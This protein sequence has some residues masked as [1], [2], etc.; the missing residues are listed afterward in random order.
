[1]I[2]YSF[3]QKY[4]ISKAGLQIGL[5]PDDHSLPYKLVPMLTAMV[6]RW[7]FG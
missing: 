4:S 7:F 2:F 3:T 1:M 5:E 6:D